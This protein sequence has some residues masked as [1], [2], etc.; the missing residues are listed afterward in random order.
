M[1]ALFNVEL[2]KR[3]CLFTTLTLDLIW[4]QKDIL[5]IDIPIHMPDYQLSDGTK[6][7]SQPVEFMICKKRDWKGVVGS[8]T[9]LKNFVAPTNT[10]NLNQEAT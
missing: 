4:P 1:F 8:L 9:Y 2:K 3:Q 6:T 5:T 10:K 7:S